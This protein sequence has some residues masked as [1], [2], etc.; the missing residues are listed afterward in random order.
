MTKTQS[1]TN[2]TRMAMNE[3]CDRYMNPP[4]SRQLDD[5]ERNQLAELQHEACEDHCVSCGQCVGKGIRQV[6]PEEW[7]DVPFRR[8]EHE[9]AHCEDCIGEPDYEQI[10]AN[11]ADFNDPSG[12]RDTW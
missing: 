5:S 9:E 7:E 8:D 11:R 4:A 2:Q 6:G 1:N 12:Y 3:L 10:I